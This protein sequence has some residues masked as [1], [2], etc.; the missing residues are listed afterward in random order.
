MKRR[1]DKIRYFIN[2]FLKYFFH[3]ESNRMN[4]A[5]MKYFM[6]SFNCLNMLPALLPVCYEDINFEI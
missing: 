3:F 4:P 2:Q 1:F 5:L 6:K